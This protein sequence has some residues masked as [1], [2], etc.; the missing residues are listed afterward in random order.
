LS[1][2]LH[3][4][5]IAPRNRPDLAHLHCQESGRNPAILQVSRPVDYGADIALGEI[6]VEPARQAPLQCAAVNLS[7]EIHDALA[8]DVADQ[9]GLE[10][11]DDAQIRPRF[12]EIHRG[13]EV[14]VR[15]MTAVD[16]VTDLNGENSQEN[17]GRGMVHEGPS[18][19]HRAPA[20]RG[21]AD[22]PQTPCEPPRRQIPAVEMTGR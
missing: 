19:E 13:V 11:A 1:H 8:G 6:A 14:C 22:R 20:E 12:R 15:R 16:R 17:D 5:R 10:G 7:I 9:T 3:H 2:H 4:D 18:R 21:G